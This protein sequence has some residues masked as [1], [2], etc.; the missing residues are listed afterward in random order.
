VAPGAQLEPHAPALQ[1]SFAAQAVVQLPQC[2]ASDETQAP[3]QLSSPVWHW[4]EPFRQLCPA[5]H[6][7]PHPPQF[8]GSEVAFTQAAPQAVCWAP[9][10]EGTAPPGLLEQPAT[11][12]R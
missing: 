8:C 11:R 7:L 5:V 6:A 12:K 1:T 9:Q 3:A 10:P 4:H 2:M